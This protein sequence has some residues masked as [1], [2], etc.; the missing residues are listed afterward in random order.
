MNTHQLSRFAQKVYVVEVSSL[1]PKRLQPSNTH[2]SR[3]DPNDT[4]R[5][6]IRQY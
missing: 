6:D 3:Y 4:R 5:K 1:A 2:I